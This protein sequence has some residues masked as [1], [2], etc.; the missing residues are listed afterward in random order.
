VP[1]P[2]TCSP[3]CGLVDSGLTNIQCYP[4]GTPTIPS[5][6]T[7]SFDLNPTGN[8]LGA[9]YSVSGGYTQ[10]GV[11]YGS[12]TTFSGSLISGGNLTITITDDATGSCQIVDLPVPAPPTCSGAVVCD[13]TSSGLTLL[14]CDPNGTPANPADDTFSF[15]LNPTGTDLGATYNVSGDITQSGISYGSATNFSGFLITDG[16][17]SITITDVST[18]CT[19][20]P[21]T[22]IAPAP[23]SFDCYLATSGLDSILCDNVATLTDETD[24]TFSFELNPTGTYLGATYSVSG[25]ITQSGI[26]YGSPT[27]FSG[28]LISAGNLNIT[29]TDDTDGS[30]TLVETIPAPPPCSLNHISFNCTSCHITHNAPGSNLTNAEF[31]ALLCQ[32][33]HISEGV[34][35]DKPLVN[36]NKASESG[37]RNSHSWDV[38]GD[39]TAGFQTNLPTNNEMLIRMPENGG[40]KEIICSTCHNQHNNGYADSPYLRVDNT[41]DAMCKDCH[42][43][44]DVQRFQDVGDN[45][46]SHPVGVVYDGGNSKL[47]ASPTDTQTVNGNV[48]CSSCHGVHDVTN[49]GVL[50]TDGNLLRT[51]NDVNLCLDCHNYIGHSGY[52]C[53][54]CHEVHNT[55]DGTIGSN[56]M[57]IRD[58]IDTPGGN[59]PVVFLA[60]S[61]ADSFVNTTGSRDGVCVVC[62]TTLSHDNYNDDTNVTHDDSSDKAGETCTSCHLHN[63][64][65]NS[66]TQPTGPQSCVSCHSSAQSGARG[67]VVQIVGSGGEMDNTLI[68]RHTTSTVGNDPLTEECEACHYESVGDHP[69]SEMMLEDSA[70]LNTVFSGSDKDVYCVGCHDGSTLYPSLFP[71]LDTDP[72]YDKS[73]YITTPHDTGNDTCLLCHERHGSQYSALTKQASNYENCFACHDGGVAS[74]N[75]SSADIAI[76]GTSGTGHAFSTDINPVSASSGNYQSNTPSDPTMDARLDSGNIVCSTCHD[77]HNANSKYLVSANDTDQMCKDC[78]NARDLG[79]FSDDIVLNKGSHPVGLAYVAGGD[80]IDPAPTLSA[81]QVGLKNGNIECSSCHGV[82]NTT[83]SDG[84]LL[85]ETMTSATCQECHNYQAHQGFDCLDCHQVHNGTNIMLIKDNIDIDPTAGVDLWPVVFNSQGTTA[86]PVQPSLHSFADGDEDGNGIYDGICEVCHTSNPSTFHYNTSAGDHSHNK[87]KSCVSCHPHR[88]TD[89]GISFPNGS[90]HD[91]HERTAPGDPQLYPATGAHEIHAGSLYEFKCSE[92][93]FGHGDGNEVP[94]GS[95]GDPDVIFDPTG[96]ASRL[97]KD[98]TTADPITTWGGADPSWDSGT[99]TCSN[100]YCHSDGQSAYRGQDGTNVWDS[101]R[102][103]PEEVAP[104]YTNQVWTGSITTCDACH[105]GKGNMTAPYTI[106]TN[107]PDAHLILDFDGV[108]TPTSGLHTHTAMFGDSQDT[109]GPTGAGAVQCYLCHNTNG[110][111]NSGTNY[112]GTYGSPLKKHVDGE[113]Y[114]IMKIYAEGG[115][116]ADWNGTAGNG[117]L[118]HCISKGNWK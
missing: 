70:N 46:G 93:H 34:A 83:T 36:A 20:G 8:N 108:Q 110:A 10:A 60:K 27:A 41:G 43:T 15:D 97:G 113:T 28:Y 103:G 66:F 85:R 95:G 75:I 17:L 26:S 55:V 111:A 115:T 49:S 106:D 84:N 47:K 44:R 63:D 87:G 74:T 67:S 51:T 30:C 35:G 69:T 2:A 16:N 38:P 50:T 7:F 107:S 86:S 96:L 102:N 109:S 4:E 72:K 81:T 58:N 5:D 56:I 88:D 101:T 12:A 18:D 33:C 54:D 91:C 9:T 25:D 62:H 6:D 52:D 77:P 40:K 59:R 48:E 23:C 13:L 76:P 61:G 89:T 65:T 98:L 90:C 114:F 92:C 105:G 45:K 73:S 68:S 19:Y 31:N 32:S 117:Y 100:I 21:F 29:I 112:Q 82:H 57:M 24:D 118:D 116:W 99:K 80:Y 37:L 94:H 1:A 42:S 39:D 11:S 64:V 53:L 22:V 3:D 104:T 79:R 71:D 14:P 78:H